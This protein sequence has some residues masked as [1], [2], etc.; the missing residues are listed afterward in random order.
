MVPKPSTQSKRIKLP[1]DHP[2]T[3][4]QRIS[5]WLSKDWSTQVSR[6]I[7]SGKGIDVLNALVMKASDCIMEFT[8]GTIL[9]IVFLNY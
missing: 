7:P 4:V 2:N 5:H 3:L 6:P 1:E 9:L 8:F